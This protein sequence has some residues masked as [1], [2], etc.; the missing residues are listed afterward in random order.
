MRTSLER[1]Y[2]FSRNLSVSMFC[3]FF[4]ARV[5]VLARWVGQ[6]EQMMYTNVLA[7]LNCSAEVCVCMC[8]WV[9]V[10]VYVCVCVCINTYDMHTHKC[11]R[12]RTHSHTNDIVRTVKSYDLAR[13]AK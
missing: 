12:T 5:P 7:R 3:L 1:V 2:F 6:F 8:L 10:C 9:V 4:S 11:N 13:Y